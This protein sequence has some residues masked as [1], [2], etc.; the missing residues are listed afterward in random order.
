MHKRVD[1]RQPTRASPLT[2]LLCSDE[3]EYIKLRAPPTHRATSKS[4]RLGHLCLVHLRGTGRTADVVP[5]IR[6]GSS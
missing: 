4:Q 2:S 5:N 1:Q 6:C 3:E